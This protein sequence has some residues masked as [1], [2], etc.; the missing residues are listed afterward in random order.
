MASDPVPYVK[1][2][3][4]SHKAAVCYTRPL[5]KEVVKGING[6]WKLESMPNVQ[7]ML[8]NSNTAANGRQKLLMGI[9]LCMGKRESE[10]L[11]KLLCLAFFFFTASAMFQPFWEFGIRV[12]S[13]F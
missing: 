8:I 6:K 11:P 10:I 5:T 12:L 1:W 7:H 13:V 9:D 2:S 3:A 4:N